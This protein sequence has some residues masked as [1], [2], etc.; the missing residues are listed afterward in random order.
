MMFESLTCAILPTDDP[1]HEWRECGFKGDYV[2]VC[3]S[4]IRSD[5]NWTGTEFSEAQKRATAEG[6]R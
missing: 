4:R 2:C 6:V 3:C 5:T 1:R